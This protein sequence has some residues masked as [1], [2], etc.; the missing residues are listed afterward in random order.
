M[1]HS[2]VGCEL[3]A[4]SR[5]NLRKAIK[6]CVCFGIFLQGYA[7]G[8]IRT[9]PP[10]QLEEI[11]VRPDRGYPMLE[12]DNYDYGRFGP[13]MDPD[14]W[15]PRDYGNGGGGS[16]E[17]FSGALGN[18]SLNASDKADCARANPILI[19][20][21]NK[22]ERDVDFTSS[23]EMG[24]YLERTYNHYSGRVG[25]FGARWLSN[26]DYGLTVTSG[27]GLG[28][29]GVWAYRPDGRAIRFLVV[30][31][32]PNRY[33]EDK[34]NPV[35]FV[36][37]QT[38]GTW[39][40]YVE[41]GSVER[42]NSVGR[43]IERK[44][45]QGLTWT[46][47]YTV[48]SGYYYL[49]RVTHT[50]GRYVEF[51]WNAGRL[52]Q[53]RDPNGKLH[54]YGYHSQYPSLATATR[55]GNPV[56]TFTYEYGYSTGNAGGL[57]GKKINGVSFSVFAY[58]SSG[59]ATLSE[60]GGVDKYTFSYTAP[61][62]GTNNPANRPPL[63][64][65]PDG[66]PYC[67]SNGQCTA[68]VS[69]TATAQQRAAL[70]PAG[71]DYEQ[72]TAITAGRLTVLE[73][74]PLNKQTTYKFLDGKLESVEGHASTWCMATASSRTYDVNGYLN[75]ETDNKGS[76][77][78][79]DYNAKG[80]LTK[81]TEAAN[82]TV[83]RVTEYE[84]D[85][86][87]NR[88]T[89]ER[90]V[91]EREVAYTYYPAS[92]RVHTVSVKNLSSYGTY[93]QVRTTTYTYTNHGNG[94]LASQVADGPRT[95]IVDAATTIYSPEGNLLSI[96]NPL[97]HMIQYK[98]HDGS[99]RPQLIQ[100]ANLEPLT[101]KY[102]DRGRLEW[103]ETTVNG[104]QQRTAYTYNVRGKVIAIS[105]PNG[106]STNYY[107]N[108]NAMRLDVIH[109]SEDG[110][111]TAVKGYS[112]NLAG[113]VLSEVVSRTT[114][115]GTPPP[116]PTCPGP[117]L[118]VPA[119]VQQYSGPGGVTLQLTGDPA[120]TSMYLSSLGVAGGQM[121]AQLD[122]RRVSY[123]DYDELNRPRAR[124][125]NGG[126]HECY[127][128]D[129]NGNLAQIRQVA[130]TAQCS[131][132]VASRTTSFGSDAFNRL[133]TVT[134]ANGF[135]VRYKYDKADRIVEVKDQRN[136]DTIYRYD[137]FGA[138]RSQTSPDTGTTAFDFDA[139]GRLTTMTR[140][141]GVT[142]TY[143]H[144]ALERVTS[145]SAQGQTQLF[146]Y[147][148]CLNGKGRLCRVTD[149]SGIREVDYTPYGWTTKLK[150][151]HYT[152]TAWS[153]MI[154]SYDGS[155]NLTRIAGNV[156]YPR[157]DYAYSRGRVTGITFSDNAS[158]SVTIASGITYHPFGS[159]AKLTYGNGLERAIGS[160][161]DGRR[162]STKVSYGST[163]YQDLTYGWNN[164]NLLQ[165]I[166]SGVAA[167][168]SQT[169][170]YDSLDRLWQANAPASV[171]EVGYDE[172]GNRTFHSVGSSLTNYATSSAN[173]R[174]QS[175][176]GATARSY[177]YTLNGNTLSYTGA[178][179]ASF[180][181]DPFNRLRTATRNG[182]TTTYFVN[183]LGQRTAKTSTNGATGLYVYQA[184]GNLLLDY[185]QTPLN[186]WRWIIR[187]YGEPIALKR[188]GNYYAIHADHLGRP[189]SVT[190][191]SRATVWRASNYAFDRVVTLDN[192]PGGLSIGFPGQMYDGETGL[193]HNGFRDYDALTGRYIQSDPAGL[194]GGLNTYAYVGG[195]PISHTDPL[196]LACNGLGCWNTPTELSLANAGNYGAYYQAACAAG[197]SYACAAGVVATG[198]GNGVGSM[199]GA[200]FTN[201]NLRYSLRRGGSNCPEKDMESIRRDLMSARVAQLSGA[202]SNNPIRVSAQS[203]SDF[204]NAI[205]SNYGASDG[206]GPFPVFGGDIPVIGNIGGW[207]WCS[208]P[209]CQP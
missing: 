65:G 191:A 206:W 129:A 107:Y 194:A 67:L 46:F 121:P 72:P 152:E 167:T 18:D 8:Q 48:I 56:T 184:D 165:T 36:E 146:E 174:L 37:K 115:P 147:D 131:T 28:M 161:L 14:P 198:Q 128:Y 145:I 114:P 15:D 30:S 24:L 120:A 41:D 208:S 109:E 47:T 202:T 189:E 94:M 50:S 113:G 32:N 42:Y 5:V 74:N 192:L 61:G 96:T 6:A 27:T 151:T 93:G 205:F 76:T 112:Y 90:L 81:K 134:D 95:D 163:I 9:E 1:N 62:F 75:I 69:A 193:W 182:V 188:Q 118:C 178:G 103:E 143:A 209:A 85:P 127:S 84:W 97:G 125:G 138:L 88:I 144:D 68:D 38:D 87:F 203:I 80:Q 110:N 148:T 157:I 142:T 111:T 156:G 195:N 106:V 108:G 105:R 168:P 22:I 29:V 199:A 33:A 92:Q 104:V 123:V 180:S 132:S 130:A 13:G 45:K 166:S 176:T 34:A 2:D 19:S 162:S 60:H 158:T 177:Q 175:L 10:D 181:Y 3:S 179:A 7:H 44:N 139:F 21:G 49:N 187:L 126:Q 78:D 207:R 159:V 183:G 117:N 55:P 54:Q 172:A 200:R 43:I 66:Q 170:Q 39:L 57:I 100:G 59:R 122:V 155:G 73:T 164:R 150:T 99:G 86:V 124:R 201:G 135:T 185:E 31:G 101:L 71:L 23:G 35:A 79:Y 91:G 133:E 40:H 16:G 196:G 141:D 160:D 77:T 153:E 4:Q 197:D 26:F 52:T 11:V 20:T 83:P 82:S 58:D 64:P 169:Y 51:T 154:H 89:L 190:D 119:A 137:G 63:P 12:P 116:P 186:D 171:L 204:H 17:T 136:K 70:V 25:L 173:N 140:H 53:V 98:N 102:D 149:P